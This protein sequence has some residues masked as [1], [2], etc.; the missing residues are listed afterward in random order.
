MAV[1]WLAANVVKLPEVP[2]SRLALSLAAEAPIEVLADLLHRA[3]IDGFLYPMPGR[4][5][6]SGWRGDYI[7]VA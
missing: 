7:P 6:T 4:D 2:V 3:A 1:P 5:M